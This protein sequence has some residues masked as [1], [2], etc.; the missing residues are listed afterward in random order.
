MHIFT[1]DFEIEF[2]YYTDKQGN[3]REIS[4]EGFF[5]LLREVVFLVGAAQSETYVFYNGQSCRQIPR[6]DCRNC[7][8]I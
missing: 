6:Y 1:I 4:Q 7:K 2:D 5:S 3:R 8:K